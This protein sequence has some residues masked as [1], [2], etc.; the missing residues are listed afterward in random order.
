MMNVDIALEE[1]MMSQ[2]VKTPETGPDV[3]PYTVPLDK[4]DPARADLFDSQAHWK[5]FERLRNEDP[6][7]FCADSEFG[8]YWSITKFKDIV[9]VDS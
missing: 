3:D 2:A 1:D 6:V 9:Y 7:H 5:Y 8:P 4:I